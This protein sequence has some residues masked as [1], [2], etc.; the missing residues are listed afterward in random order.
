VARPKAVLAF[1][2]GAALGALTIALMFRFAFGTPILLSIVIVAAIV[3]F[4]QIDLL[5]LELWFGLQKAI[6]FGFVTGALG[7]VIALAVFAKAPP[8]NPAVLPTW[9]LTDLA[10]RSIKPKLKAWLAARLGRPTNHD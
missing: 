6:A 9:L 4:Y 10:L 2:S 3:A 7:A 5:L 1:M 8:G